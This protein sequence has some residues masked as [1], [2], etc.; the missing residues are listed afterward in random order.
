[1]NELLVDI[2]NQILIIEERYHRVHGIKLSMT[3]VHTLEGISKSETKMM[4]DVAAHL[5]ITQGTLTTTINRLTHKG[6][7]YREQDTRDRRIFR[8]VLTEKGE[9]VVD[10]H[11]QF[12][13]EMIDRLLLHLD[14]SDDL[15]ASVNQINTFF[16]ELYD[17]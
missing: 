4:S 1:M 7:V 10:I 14:D 6:Y 3:E 15:I 8:L 12:H 9:E 13:E 16:K 2:F 17:I 5:R 11:N